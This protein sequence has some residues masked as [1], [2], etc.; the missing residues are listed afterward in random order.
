[1]FYMND[2]SF[3]CLLGVSFWT[4]L[5]RDVFSNSIKILWWSIFAKIVNDFSPLTIFA[6]KDPS[7]MFEWVLNKL[8]AKMPEAYT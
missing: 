3:K 4:V 6:K 5:P 8:W 2:M 7:F 1:M